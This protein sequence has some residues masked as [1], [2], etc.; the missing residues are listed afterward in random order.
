MVKPIII[1]VIQMAVINVQIRAS[2][3]NQRTKDG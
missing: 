1:I 2:N 3:G